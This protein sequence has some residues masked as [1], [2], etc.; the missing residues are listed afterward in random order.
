VSSTGVNPYEVPISSIAILHRI[1]V[2]RCDILMSTEILE[3]LLDAEIF[4]LTAQLKSHNLHARAVVYFE[5][6][7]DFNESGVAII[8]SGLNYPRN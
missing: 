1:A 4:T 2:E 3:V 7:R 5:L 6:K 8:A